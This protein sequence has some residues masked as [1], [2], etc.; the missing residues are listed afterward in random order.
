MQVERRR[1]LINAA[2]MFF[3]NC[4]RCVISQAGTSSPRVREVV[5]VLG[6]GAARWHTLGSRWDLVC[7]EAPSLDGAQGAK[8]KPPGREQSLIKL[9]WDCFVNICLPPWPPGECVAGRRRKTER[10][11]QQHCVE[12]LLQEKGPVSHKHQT[13]GPGVCNNAAR[14]LQPGSALDGSKALAL[15]LAYGS[16]KHRCSEGK[17]ANNQE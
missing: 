11:Q 5:R 8:S 13:G 14:E 1:N 4:K 10:C 15:W 16:V 12:G 7:Q 9:T 6:R 17:Q 2:K 3:L